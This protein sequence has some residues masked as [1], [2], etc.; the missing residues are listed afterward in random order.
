MKD[1]ALV[2]KHFGNPE[3]LLGFMR[4]TRKPVFHKS[5]LFFR[6]IQFAVR[7][8]FDVIERSPISTPEAE[9]MARKIVEDYEQKGILRQVNNQAYRLEYPEWK[10]PEDGTYAM[11]TIHGAPLPIKAEAALETASEGL[12]ESEVVVEELGKPKGGDV[13]AE[14]NR[15][16]EFV[17]PIAPPKNAEP[18]HLD[19]RTFKPG[20][21][22]YRFVKMRD[23]QAGTDNKPE[24]GE[25]KSEGETEI[26]PKPKIAPLPWL[27]KN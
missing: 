7:D 25:R 1:E 21:R 27:K 10:T 9:R 5:N 3:V 12:A 18:G 11:L 20:E 2:E 23:P 24:P 15:I 4:R 6:D 16:A 26:P 13:S 14:G 22:E 17:L 19:G 8:Y